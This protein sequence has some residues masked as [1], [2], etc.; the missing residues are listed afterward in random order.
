MKITSIEKPFKLVIIMIS[1][2]LKVF[3]SIFDL[4]ARFLGLDIIKVFFL[5][6]AI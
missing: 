3:I 1:S 5:E 4:K 2:I 6:S